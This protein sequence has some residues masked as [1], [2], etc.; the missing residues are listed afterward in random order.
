MLGL[1]LAIVNVD[2][3]ALFRGRRRGSNLLGL[4]LAIVNVDGVALFRGRW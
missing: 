2:G 1:N 3:M 4:N